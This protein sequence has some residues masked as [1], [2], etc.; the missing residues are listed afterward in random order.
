MHFTHPL[1]PSGGRRAIAQSVCYHRANR[2]L[3][4]FCRAT[5]RFC[6]PGLIRLL[7]ATAF[8]VV[9]GFSA[10]AH[11]QAPGPQGSDDNV[12]IEPRK[13]ADAP[14]NPAL[15]DPSL[16]TTR[17]PIKVDVDLVLVPVTVTDP[18]N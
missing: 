1:V 18:M 16:K 6:K 13:P 4:V 17:R 9:L 8:L 2:G 10:P 12:H 3:K 7:P 14:P 5:I 15:N 11:S